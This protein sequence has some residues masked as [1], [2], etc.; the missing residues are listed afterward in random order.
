MESYRFGGVWRALGVTLIALAVAF[1]LLMYTNHETV[2][3]QASLTCVAFVVLGVWCYVHFSRYRVNIGE[4]GFIVERFGRRPFDVSWRDVVSVR[5][6]EHEITFKT[7]DQRKIAI[8]V[9]FPGLEALEAAYARYLPD[10][11][12]AAPTERPDVP[13]L[14]TSEQ[15]HEYHRARQRMWLVLSRRWFVASVVEV[16]ITLTASLALEHVPFRQLPRL[17]ALALVYLF[18]LAESHGYAIGIVF[19]GFAVMFGIMSLQE[20]ARARRPPAA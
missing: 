12:F 15:R 13:Q 14:L 18:T 8:S 4:E 20:A 1:P 19:V 3:L 2:D 11:V 6:N 10:V 7:T 9:Y 5:R 16:A 17:V